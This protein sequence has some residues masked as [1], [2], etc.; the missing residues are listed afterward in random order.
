MARKPRSTR[1]RQ[2][3]VPSSTA[4]IQPALEAV[5]P[6]SAEEQAEPTFQEYRYIVGDLRRMILL[7]AAIFA[8]LIALSF[9]VS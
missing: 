2:R 3:N 4:S 9:F 5:P 6:V 8:L 7:A 1:K